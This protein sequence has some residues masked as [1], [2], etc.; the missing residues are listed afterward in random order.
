MT[1]MTIAQMRERDIEK[2][3]EMTGAT[4][5]TTRKIFNS[6]YRYSGLEQRLLVLENDCEFYERRKWW[7]DHEEERAE[8]WRKRL[9]GWLNPYGLTLYVSGGYPKICIRDPKTGGIDIKFY[10]HYYN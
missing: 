2:F 3:M 7:L 8:K 4:E 10:G 1:Q 5:E 6:F 9:M